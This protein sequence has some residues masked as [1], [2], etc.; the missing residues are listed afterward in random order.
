MYNLSTSGHNEPVAL[1]E[2]AVVVRALA[3][4]EQIFLLRKGGIIEETRDFRLVSPTF[5]LMETY[6]HQKAELLKE[7]ARP[8]LKETLQAWQPD[9]SQMRLSLYGEVTEELEIR[10]QETLDKLYP[11]HIW[12]EELAEKRLKW[13]RKQPL[14][15]LFIRAWRLEKP[16]EVPVRDPYLGCKSWVRLEDG[17]P[18][19]NLEEVMSQQTYESRCR[20]IRQVLNRG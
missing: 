15:L 12:T 6:E 5:Y 19:S 4:G 3:S 18:E 1:K 16:A 11:Y 13:K 2:W 9:A 17:V 20:E 8:T 10:D 7:A 14:H